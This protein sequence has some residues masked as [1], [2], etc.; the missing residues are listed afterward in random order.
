[1]NESINSSNATA[2]LLKSIAVCLGAGLFL[3]IIAPL[4]TSFL[5]FGERLVYWMGLCLAGCLGGF[6]GEM[7]CQRFFPRLPKFGLILSVSFFASV[8]VFAALST[9]FG[10]LMQVFNLATFFYIFVISLAITSVSYAFRKEAIQSKTVD[11]RRPALIERL[12]AE[13][14]EAEIFAISAEDHYVKVHTSLGHAMILMRFKDAVRDAAPLAGVV[15]H[16]SWW[17]AEK[18]VKSIKKKSRTAELTLKN[19][20]LALVSRSGLSAMRDSGWID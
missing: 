5:G 3:T 11:E 13:L 12:P 10:H 20:V 7:L 6:L 9:V 15:S 18:G 16:R 1:M 19:D 17:V 2:Q 4:G 14:R 8:F